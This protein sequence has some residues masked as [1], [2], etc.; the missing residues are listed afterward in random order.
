MMWKTVQWN[1]AP[2]S[3]PFPPVC[4]LWILHRMRAATCHTAGPGCSL[5]RG[6]VWAQRGT[7]GG[8]DLPAFLRVRVV[9][10]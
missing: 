1:I 6:G 9:R 10:H 7:H 2:T 3:L 4:R 8:E 5:V